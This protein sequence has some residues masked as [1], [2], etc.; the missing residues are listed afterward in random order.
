MLC[1]P[2]PPCSA[3]PRNM[4][5]R[6]IPGTPNRRTSRK[7]TLLHFNAEPWSIPAVPSRR[8]RFCSTTISPQRPTAEYPCMHERRSSLHP[9]NAQANYTCSVLAQS[10]PEYPRS[11]QQLA[12]PNGYIRVI[13]GLY[14][15][16][17]KEN[18]NYYIGLYR[19]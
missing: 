14:V 8:G 18:G 5:P 9:C 17:G 12:L 4:Q 19:V 3:Q 11:A 10:I 13:L 6:S 7:V 16:N 15:D 2:H 1:S